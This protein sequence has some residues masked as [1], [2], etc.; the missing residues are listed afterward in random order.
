MRPSLISFEPWC[1]WWLV[2]LARWASW[3]LTAAL[4]FCSWSD[5]WGTRSQ[6]EDFSH[7]SVFWVCR[8]SS[9]FRSA[10]WQVMKPPILPGLSNS[11]LKGDTCGKVSQHPRGVQSKPA[12]SQM[13]VKGRWILGSVH[14]LP[15]LFV[16]IIFQVNL[17]LK[18]V[19]VGK[20][21][22]KCL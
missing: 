9:A 16:L 21:K 5:W 2:I 20:S 14:H 13:S 4:L 12:R 15:G 11:W 17:L 7:Y 18:E 1:I 6:K 8:K 3:L 10:S 22:Q 19:W